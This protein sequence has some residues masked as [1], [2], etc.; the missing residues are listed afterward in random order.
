MPQELG[1]DVE[2]PTTV[3]KCLSPRDLG[4]PGP[5]PL[6]RKEVGKHL[7]RHEEALDGEPEAITVEL[8]VPVIEERF[9]RGSRLSSVLFQE[10]IGIAA[11]SSFLWTEDRDLRV[12]APV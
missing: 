4:S 10:S 6:A 3:S 9:E 7:V 1:C 11:A 12:L 5:G 2:P 8:C